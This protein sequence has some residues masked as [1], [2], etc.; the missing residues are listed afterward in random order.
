MKGTVTEAKLSKSGKSYIVQIAGQGYFAK[1]DSKLD[2]A[3]GK[4]ID[5]SVDPQNYQGKTIN[6][7]RDWDFEREQAVQV[8]SAIPAPVVAKPLPPLPDPLAVHTSLTDAELR[9][10]SNVVGQGILAKTI[11]NPLLISVW[12][13]AARETLR[14]LD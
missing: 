6:W 4:P 13:K 5:F 2:Q 10:I 7:V 3:V 9:F 1:L 14:E 11:D 8:G 12:A